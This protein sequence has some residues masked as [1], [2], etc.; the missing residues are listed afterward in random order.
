MDKNKYLCLH[1]ELKFTRDWDNLNN[2]IYN[3]NNGLKL[4]EYNKY[5]GA[6]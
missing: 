3:N 1:K 4:T 2:K 6:G 5:P